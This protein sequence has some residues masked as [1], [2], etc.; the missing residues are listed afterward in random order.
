MAFNV[1]IVGGVALKFIEVKQY[2]AEDLS[3]NLIL[4]KKVDRDFAVTKVNVVLYTP[5]VQ[6]GLA[7]GAYNAAKICGM[8]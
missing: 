7:P 4:I 1:I 8:F 6:A 2:A 5:T 3:E